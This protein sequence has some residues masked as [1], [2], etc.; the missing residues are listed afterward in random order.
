MR[1]NG[2][3]RAQIR[4]KGKPILPKEKKGSFDREKKNKQ[5]TKG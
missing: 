4:K 5:I 2:K 1:G 3:K